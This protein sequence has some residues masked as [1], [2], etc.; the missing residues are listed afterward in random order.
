MGNSSPKCFKCAGE[1]QDANLF[2]NIQTNQDN[3][4]AITVIQTTETR[5]AG[6][7]TMKEGF[8]SKSDLQ[9]LKEE[10][11]IMQKFAS[12]KKA[13]FNTVK[14]A[15]DTSNIKKNDLSDLTGSVKKEITDQ[16]KKFNDNYD[17]F[18]KQQINDIIN[19]IKNEQA[20]TSRALS[21]A[22]AYQFSITNTNVT[23]EQR[24]IAAEDLRQINDYLNKA[25]DRINAARKAYSEMNKAVTII[26]KI[27]DTPC[28]YEDSAGWSTCKSSNCKL[29]DV[30]VKSSIARKK[31][32]KN[33]IGNFGDQQFYGCNSKG[34]IVNG[35]NSTGRYIGETKDCNYTCPCVYSQKETPVN[36]NSCPRTCVSE[37]TTREINKYRNEA[38]W[39]IYHSLESGPASC[40]AKCGKSGMQENC[41]ENKSIGKCDLPNPPLCDPVGFQ[42]NFT[43]MSEGFSALANR[44]L[45]GIKHECPCKMAGRNDLSSVKPF[46][47]DG[48]YSSSI[49]DDSSKGIPVIIQKHRNQYFVLQDAGNNNSNVYSDSWAD[50]PTENDTETKKTPKMDVIT[51]F[52]FGSLSVVALFIV[53]RMIQKSR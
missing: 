10:L 13:Q 17:I 16:E 27:I 12:E 34:N 45:E 7:A 25:A 44:P 21:T 6:F 15:A 36:G 8:D 26:E 9:T 42:Q 43:T 52:Y 49:S 47:D 51:Q 22:R 38:S 24:N 11:E 48:E 2:N 32:I 31:R 5:R 35:D 39:Y 4:N 30:T 1:Q 29:G 3:T 37:Q 14:F 23:A 33:W 20:S 40:P 19:N 50:I 28:E 46:Y 53:F 41:Q 18:N